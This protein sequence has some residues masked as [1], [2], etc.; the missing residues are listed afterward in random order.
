MMRTGL[1]VYLAFSGVSMTIPYNTIENYQL[2]ATLAD[3]LTGYTGRARSR[4][5]ETFYLET[6][7]QLDALMALQRKLGVVRKR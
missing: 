2:A 1:E 6:I 5:G 7:D 4:T 3:K